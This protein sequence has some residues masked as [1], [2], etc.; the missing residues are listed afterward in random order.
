ML[1]RVIETSR[2]TLCNADVETSSLI[3][4]LALRAAAVAVKHEDDRRL[5]RNAALRKRRKE[6]GDQIDPIRR[7]NR[8]NGDFTAADGLQRG[9]QY[10]FSVNEKVIIKGNRRTP[11]KFVGKEAVITSQCL[12]G[13][14]LLKIIETGENVRLQYRSLRKLLNSPAMEDQCPTQPIQNSSS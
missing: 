9:V 13:W 4:N 8:E 2:C 7:V 10:P 5:F 14:Y 3:P 12:N 1:R 11:E 6:M